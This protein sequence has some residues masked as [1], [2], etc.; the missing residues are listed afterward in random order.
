MI[1]AN[2]GIISSSSIATIPSTLSNNLL[3]YYKAENNANDS[4][5]VNN[6]TAFGGLTYVAGKNGNAFNLNGTTAYVQLGDVM[7]L[8][9]SSW[10]YSM[11]FNTNLSSTGQILF[12]KTYYGGLTGRFFAYLLNNKVCFSFDADIGFTKITLESVNTI[13]TNTWYNAVFVFDRSDKIRIYLNGTLQ[14]VN[15]LDQTNNLI[16]YASNN[17][18]TNNPF[19]IGASTFSDNTTPVDFFSGKMDEFGIWNRVLTQSEITE[20]QTKYYPF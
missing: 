3:S 4:L 2:H 7:D 19:R 5:S 13:S 1:L 16:P 8:G 15:S 11:W 18:N 12:G 14:S 10:T 17:L 6:G 9:Y 20:L